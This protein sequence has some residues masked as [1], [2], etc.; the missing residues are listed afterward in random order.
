[1][2]VICFSFFFIPVVIYHWDATWRTARYVLPIYFNL[3][4]KQT[5]GS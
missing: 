2:S 1:M 5:V 3:F 4:F